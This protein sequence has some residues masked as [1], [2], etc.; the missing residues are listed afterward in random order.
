MRYTVEFEEAVADFDVTRTPSVLLS[1]NGESVPVELPRENP[2]DAEV[3]D[4]VRGILEGRAELRATVADAYGTARL[5]DAER[6]SLSTGGP[7][8]P[9]LSQRPSRA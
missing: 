7:V 1:R 5:L 9:A 4:F 2:Y 3:G 6:E 8:S